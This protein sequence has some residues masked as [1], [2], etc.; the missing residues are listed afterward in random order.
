M[1]ERDKEMS[2]PFP[3]WE[4]LKLP[5]EDIKKIEARHRKE[6]KA[7]QKSNVKSWENL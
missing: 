1:K 3:F 4:Q 6:M 5:A 7:L 2:Q